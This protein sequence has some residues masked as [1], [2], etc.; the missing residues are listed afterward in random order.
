MLRCP[1][2]RPIFVLQVGHA[3]FNPLLLLN[4]STTGGVVAKVV[5]AGAVDVLLVTD[6]AVHPG[7]QYGLKRKWNGKGE[8]GGGVR[9]ICF[10]ICNSNICL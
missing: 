9:Q 10:L 3:N 1:E 5:A 7:E 6:A 8:R 4:P 2:G